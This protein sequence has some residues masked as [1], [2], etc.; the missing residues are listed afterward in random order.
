[1]ATADAFVVAATAVLPYADDGASGEGL[2]LRCVDGEARA[3]HA[4]LEMLADFTGRCNAAPGES[5]P[6]SRMRA[7]CAAPPPPTF[8]QFA[9]WFRGFFDA[10]E[11]FARSDAWYGN[12][13]HVLCIE[14]RRVVGDVPVFPPSDA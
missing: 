8:A 2:L 9:V 10:I 5:A 3:V 6:L 14:I 4:A 7:L 1:M 13:K 12:P 11:E